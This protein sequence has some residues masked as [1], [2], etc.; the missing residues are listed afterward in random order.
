MNTLH[1]TNKEIQNIRIL[2]DHELVIGGSV[3]IH[4]SVRNLVDDLRYNISRYIEPGDEPEEIELWT[5]AE[6]RTVTPA[7]NRQAKATVVDLLHDAFDYFFNSA[8][9]SGLETD[10]APD[11]GPAL[12]PEVYDL[13]DALLSTVYDYDIAYPETELFYHFLAAKGSWWVAKFYG[14]LKA[15][16]LEHEFFARYLPIL[17]RQAPWRHAEEQILCSS[18]GVKNQ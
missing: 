11:E 2:S 9:S 16:E 4:Q 8:A 10:P 12:L 6:V 15:I 18:S 5:I 7:E 17:Q 14:S 13:Q 3:L 1:T